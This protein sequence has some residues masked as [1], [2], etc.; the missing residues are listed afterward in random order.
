MFEQPQAEHE[1]LQRLVG[2]WTFTSECIMG[3]DQPPMTSDGS[4]V[5]R[6][7]GGMWILVE[8]RNGVPE[9]P[10]VESVITLGFDPKV[11]QYVG[12]FV[13][14]CMTLLWRYAGSLDESKRRLTLDTEGPRFGGEGTAQYQDIIEIIDDDH[15]IMSSHLLGDDGQWHS[16]MT[17]HYRRA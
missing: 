14:S 6:S 12:T 1:W 17:A 8:G 7:L 4:A 3:P 5:V 9:G 11:R 16:F 15:W 13:A 2:R 10:E